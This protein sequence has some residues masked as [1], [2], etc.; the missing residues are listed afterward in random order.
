MRY[1]IWQYRWLSAP[2]RLRAGDDWG[3]TRALR[4]QCSRWR[5]GSLQWSRPLDEIDKA[6]EEDKPSVGIAVIALALHHEEPLEVLPRV[7]RALESRDQ[8]IRHQGVAAPAHVAR[9]HPTVD[10]RCLDLL[11]AYPRGNE[12]DDDL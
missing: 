6:F 1:Q 4:R 9:L 5:Y 10:H 11:R 12:A 3:L 8:A 7:S 2:A